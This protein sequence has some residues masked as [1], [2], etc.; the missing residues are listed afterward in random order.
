MKKRYFMSSRILQWQNRRNSG[1]KCVLQNVRGVKL[2]KKTIVLSMGNGWEH[3]KKK[4]SLRVKW[5]S[6]QL[7][8]CSRDHKNRGYC[9]Q[10]TLLTATQKSTGIIKAAPSSATVIVC[11]VVRWPRVENK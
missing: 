11:G 5:K 2:K 10:F 9:T 3:T 1:E 6:I 7:F 8:K 4:K